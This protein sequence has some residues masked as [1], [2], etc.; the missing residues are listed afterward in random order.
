MKP[1][2]IHE[3]SGSIPGLTQWIKD[4]QMWC[5]SQTQPGS[6][7]A[8]TVVQAGGCSS[9]W[10]LYAEGVALKREKRKEREKEKEGKE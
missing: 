2:S 8:V 4:L 1:T 9:N 6:G 3:D 7:V 10:T 5:R